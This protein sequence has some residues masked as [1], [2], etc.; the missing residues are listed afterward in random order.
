[1]KLLKK[2]IILI[3]IALIIQSS[4]LLFLDKYYFEIDSKASVP[5]FINKEEKSILIKASA[6]S[7][8][9]KVSYDG[10][11]LSFLDTEQLNVVNTVLGTVKKVKIE[12][13]STISFY[14]W[15]PDNNKIIYANKISNKK[16]IIISFFYYDVKNNN[17]EEV[18]GKNINNSIT[19]EDF[20]PNSQI[21]DII[22]TPIS[23]VMYVKLTKTDG[24]SLIYKSE[25]MY[26]MK[27]THIPPALIGNIK[28]TPGDG[29]LYYDDLKNKKIKNSIGNF[30]NVPKVEI[31]MILGSDSANNIYIGDVLNS[32]ITKLY[33]GILNGNSS[34][35][36]SKELKTPTDMK[37]IY[38]TLQ[39]KIYINDGLMGVVTE[40]NSGI[41]TPY[42]GV[43]KCMYDKGIASID[44]ERVVKT[45][46]KG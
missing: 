34:S 11:Y 42:T 10:L 3:M 23:N 38:I 13:N 31:P 18:R 35:F 39:G 15:L 37:N 26:G 19:I 32:K 6:K 2:I 16:G 30:I 1:M 28:S 21:T 8:E 17:S 22:V 46:F 33:W 9:F 5:T 14:K 27:R 25:N 45:P 24:Q 29:M 4:I 12:E 44:E 7:K 36:T 43:L 40:L 20:N 41:E